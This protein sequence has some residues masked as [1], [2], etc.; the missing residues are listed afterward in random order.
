[1]S[2]WCKPGDIL[3]YPHPPNLSTRLIELGERLEDGK[4]PIEFYHVALALGPYDKLEADGKRVEVNPID[5]GKFIAYRPPIP[6]DRRDKALAEMRKYIGQP[7][8]WW[9]IL[10]DAL[11]YLTRGVVHLPVRFISSQE[12]RKKVCSSLVARYLAA[13]EWGPKLGP[14]SS[15][16]DLWLAVR[17]YPVDP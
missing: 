14:N 16:E 17:E 7:Y 12:R 13:A 1:M 15:P 2:D 9:L 11:R 6:K 5:Y 4:Q 8:D 10:D 3:L